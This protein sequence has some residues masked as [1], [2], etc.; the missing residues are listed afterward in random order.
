MTE[1]FVLGLD[2]SMNSTG[3]AV[4]GVKG[5]A[6]RLIDSGIVKA[7]TKKAHGERLTKQRENFEQILNEY[8]I[9]YA[10]REAGFSQHK[11][12]TQ[13]LFKAYGVAEEY[14]SKMGLVEYAASTIKKVVTGSGRASKT[15][16]QQ[17]IEVELNLP[18]DFEFK[19]D[20]E[21]DAMGVALTLIEKKKL[22]KGAK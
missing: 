2:V 13:V 19:S 21:S 9:E 12:A 7:N 16:L 17:A 1:I 3:W 14:F 15:E 10:A 22:R 5:E 11:K 18:D 20:D 8:P 6:V 4:L